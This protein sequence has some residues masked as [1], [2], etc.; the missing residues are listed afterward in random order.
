MMTLV[1]SKTGSRISVSSI[2]RIPVVVI[3]N[4]AE[5]PTTQLNR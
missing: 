5:L 2:C 4:T 3:L 1:F